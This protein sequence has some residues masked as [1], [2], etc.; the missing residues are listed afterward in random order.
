MQNVNVSYYFLLNYCALK[1][2]KNHWAW[3]RRWRHISWSAVSV[4]LFFRAVLSRLTAPHQYPAHH[5]AR[6]KSARINRSVL[7][8]S[9]VLAFSEAINKT[10]NLSFCSV[11]WILKRFCQKT[12]NIK[13]SIQWWG[14]FERKQLYSSAQICRYDNIYMKTNQY[15]ISFNKIIV[16]IS[17]VA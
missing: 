11:V 10:F 3:L 13:V 7:G 12:R 1:K 6:R 9:R 17:P 4:S 8:N 2:C 16:I 14:S 5:I 15:N